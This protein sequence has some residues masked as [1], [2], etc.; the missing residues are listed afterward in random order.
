MYKAL[1]EYCITQDA[2][3][4]DCPG[5]I[6][7]MIK[8]QTKKDILYDNISQEDRTEVSI[9]SCVVLPDDFENDLVII[10]SS[11][12]SHSKAFAPMPWSI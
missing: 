2:F 5:I 3:P 10:I 4:Y 1:E 12:S 9:F 7:L 8:K 11:L 6:V